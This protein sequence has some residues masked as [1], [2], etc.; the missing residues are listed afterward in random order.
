LKPAQA[1]RLDRV[2]GSGVTGAVNE[3][4]QRAAW[5][6]G[7]NKNLVIE[8][9]LYNLTQQRSTALVHYGPNRT[10]QFVLVRFQQPEGQQP[11]Q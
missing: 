5:R 8:T 9:G 6:V 7:A 2:R 4:D 3:E 10:Q 11:Q 1:A